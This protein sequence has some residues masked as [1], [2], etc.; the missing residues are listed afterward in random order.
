MTS[1]SC[2]LS[3]AEVQCAVVVH[4]WSKFRCWKLPWRILLLG[5]FPVYAARIS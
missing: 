1:D 4:Q 3:V 5:I 2:C